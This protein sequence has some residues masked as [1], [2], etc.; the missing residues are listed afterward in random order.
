[1]RQNYSPSSDP[2]LDLG[3]EWKGQDGKGTEG[4]EER[5]KGWR[6]GL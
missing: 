3:R 2:N 4:E 1:M 5:E 6:N